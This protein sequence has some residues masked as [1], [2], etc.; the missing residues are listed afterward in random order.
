MNFDIVKVLINGYYYGQV[1]GLLGSM[2]QEPI[3]DFKLPDGK[4]I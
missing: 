1:A 4:V 3:F 2:N